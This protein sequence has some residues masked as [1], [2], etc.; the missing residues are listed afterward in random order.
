MLSWF[1]L[2]IERLSLR[3]AFYDLASIGSISGPP[4]SRLREGHIDSYTEASTVSLGYMRSN[5][6]EYY[7]FSCEGL[8]THLRS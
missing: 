3:V 6:D 5:I 2:D 7:Q 1:C 4:L 8:T